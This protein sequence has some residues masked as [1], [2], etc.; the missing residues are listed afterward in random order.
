VIV[1]SRVPS[2]RG[3]LGVGEAD[4]VDRHKGVAEHLRQGRDVR[5]HLAGTDR[6]VGPRGHAVV[7]RLELLGHRG[8]RRPARAGAVPAHER[9]AQDAQQVP[10]IVV[11]AQQ[12]RLGE[13]ARERVLDEVLGVLA[14]AA[15][16]PRR[17]VQTVDVIAE[18]GRIQHS[19]IAGHVGPSI[20]GGAIRRGGG[21]LRSRPLH[22]CA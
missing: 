20:R 22:R 18:A 21:D 19:R 4:D 8:R 14:R 11:V 13:H 5:E 17:P 2:A 1:A 12:A 9:V 16:R 6:R 3:R 7:D 10:E 15:Q